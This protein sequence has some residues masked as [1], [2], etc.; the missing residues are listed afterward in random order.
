MTRNWA[1]PR[2]EKLVAVVVPDRRRHQTAWADHPQHF[3]DGTCGIR[4]EVQN[5][6]GVCTIEW[7]PDGHI[8]GREGSRDEHQS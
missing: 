2:C 8:W 3:S 4:E 6:T 1:A 5:W 7:R